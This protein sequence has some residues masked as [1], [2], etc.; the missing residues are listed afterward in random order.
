MLRLPL[1]KAEPVPIHSMQLST[2]NSFYTNDLCECASGHVE[3]SPHRFVARC[4]VAL[5]RRASAEHAGM[6]T[7]GGEP[8][9]LAPSRS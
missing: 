8:T 7:R 1:G 5:Q 6:Y 3:S 9:G 4:I 2:S